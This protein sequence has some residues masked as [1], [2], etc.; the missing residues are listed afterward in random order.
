[1]P[2]GTVELVIVYLAGGVTGDE[3]E[4]SAGRAGR[5]PGDFVSLV[6]TFAGRLYGLGSAAARKRLPAASGRCPR[7]GGR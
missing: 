3:E 5:A 2:S 4:G 1:M 7:G 6:I